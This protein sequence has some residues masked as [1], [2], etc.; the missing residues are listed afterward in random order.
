MKNKYNIVFFTWKDKK[1]P[2]A[3]GAE[4]INEEIA[5][6]LVQYGHKVIFLV[7][8][9]KGCLPVEKINGYK[10]IRLGGRW[11]IYWHALRYYKK[12]LK[13]WTNLI[14]EEI[15]TVPFFTQFYTRDKKRILFIDQL[16]RQIWFYQIFF[17]LNLIGYLLEPIYLRILKKN[18]CVTIS[19][20]TQIDLQKYG[21]KK[22]NIF[23]IPI[24]INIKSAE[25]LN[26]IKKYS[27][28]TLLSLGMIRKMKRTL[29][30]VKAF[31]LAKKE[32]PELKLK[33]A[34][35]AGNKYGKKVLK[36]I[37]RSAY[38]SDIQYLGKITKDQK[39]KFLQKCHIITVTSVKE[40]WGIIVTEAGS[41]GTPAIVYNVDGLCDSVKDNETGIICDVNS[42]E[43]LG[44]EVI[45][46]LSD[47]EKYHKLQ[48]NAWQWSKKFS[49]YKST[50]EFENII[51]Q[52]ENR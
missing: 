3:G 9:F 41:Q 29:D 16:C 21:F 25:H 48:Y 35:D 12:N 42:P 18:K 31:E 7:A 15:N 30:Q 36:Y 34:G 32:I 2:E 13:N 5:K 19:K 33:I 51:K 6:R 17:P 28:P 45:K 23:I 39:I 43:N 22:E 37:N 26:K 46:L 40:G 1:N 27:E 8:G 14:I 24:D 10:I 4:L 11:T 44:D 52:M 38:K 50:K 20:S 49:W 47:K